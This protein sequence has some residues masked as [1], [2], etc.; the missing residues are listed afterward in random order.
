MPLA[1]VVMFI[2]LHCESGLAD[3]DRLAQSVEHFLSRFKP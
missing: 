2:S 1:F 3:K